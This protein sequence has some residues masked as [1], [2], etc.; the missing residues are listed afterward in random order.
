MFDVHAHD[1]GVPGT[2]SN[3]LRRCCRYCIG[4]EWD[5]ITSTSSLTQN[6]T[7]PPARDSSSQTERRSS[8][9]GNTG[10]GI[11]SGL[12]IRLDT[13][14]RRIQTPPLRGAVAASC[15]ITFRLNEAQ[16]QQSPPVAG[17]T[18][19]CKPGNFKVCRKTEFPRNQRPSQAEKSHVR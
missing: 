8:R 9:V 12:K 4:T 2:Q 19:R 14:Q 16:K 13:N 3:A 18:V 5:A 6:T 17:R 7:Q 15:L 10:A 11:R 1:S